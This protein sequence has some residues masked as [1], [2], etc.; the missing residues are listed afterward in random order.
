MNK[1]AFTLVELIAVLLLLGVLGLIATV[2]ISNELKENKQTL[3]DIQIDNIKRSAQNWASNNVFNLPDGDGEYIVI[4]LGELK[5]Q[6][7]SEDVINPKTNE[8]FNDDLQIKITLIEN[9]YKYDV[10]L[11]ENE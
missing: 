8:P 10:L 7:L 1:K 11:D 9:T 5:Q 4:T 6:G 2:T 3:Y